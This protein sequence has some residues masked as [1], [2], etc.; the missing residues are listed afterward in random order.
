MATVYSL[1]NPIN[2]NVYYVG[3]TTKRIEERLLGHLAKPNTETTRMLVNIGLSPII[4]IIESGEIVSKETELYWIK[5][6]NEEAV[7]LE[8][9]DGLI[10]YQKRTGNISDNLLNSIELTSEEKMRSSLEMIIKELPLSSSIPIVQRI[11]KLAEWAL[12]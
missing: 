10:N 12:S 4:N 5:K 2:G 9:K 3:F 1:T 7:L 11:K 8:N 6:L